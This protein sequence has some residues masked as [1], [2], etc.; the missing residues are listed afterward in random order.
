MTDVKMPQMGESIAEGTISVWLIDEGQTVKAD[1]PLVTVSTDK[2]DV[3]VP[4][5][6][7]GV[8]AE[9]IAKEGETVQVGALIA[10]IDE[11]TIAVG[12]EAQKETPAEAVAGKPETPAA[13]PGEAA[14]GQP[15][16]MKPS[17]GVP[18][19]EIEKKVETAKVETAPPQE[20]SEAKT[21]V[22]GKPPEM[23]VKRD[24]PAEHP[25][26]PEG[27]PAAEAKRETRPGE[28]VTAPPEIK[29]EV[30][31]PEAVAEA[32]TDK[33]GFYSP[34]VMRLA[35]EHGV[36]LKAIEGTGEG[37]RVTRADVMRVLGEKRAGPEGTVPPGG[38]VHAPEKEMPSPRI[39]Q[40]ELLES[41]AP[42]EMQAGYGVYKPPS[43]EVEEGD[44][45]LPFSR[46]RLLIA[47][48]MVYSK[49]TSA[50]V[51]T[52]AEADFEQIV[53]IRQ[54]SKDKVKAEVGISL[55][56]TPFVMAAAIRILKEFPLM[57][58]VVQGY[59]VL[60]KRH[61]NLGVAVDSE[62]GLMVPVIKAAED[63]SLLDLAKA[64]H[65]LSV[66]VRDKK[67]T[68]DE[69]TGGTFTVTNPGRHGNLFG[70]PIISQPQVGI[71]R[72][73]E[74]VKRAVV[75]TAED[76]EDAIAIRPMMYLALS[77]DHRVVDGLT[78]NE[79]LHRIKD[80]LEAGDF[81]L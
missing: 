81:A 23:A 19:A 36:D 73:G 79:F 8:L 38:P 17:E 54:R 28:E 9:I 70:T 50:H 45:E 42:P 18:G 76:G 55:T 64:L 78:A 14:S 27:V 77:Y 60:T 43:Y 74:L 31:E 39:V 21:T 24:G 67:I 71:L 5:P 48:H 58:S 41:A 59:S 47:D 16:A 61:I 3:D 13:K 69:L 68:P 51:T 25:A 15:E 7:S 30:P 37:G 4:S 72:M 26:R 6:I 53:G 65:A 12:T 40:E 57:N 75:V 33:S 22:E 29:R 56:Y 34:A 52:I 1:E 2:A 44:A 11:K 32:M 20:T 63:M 66:R 62:R 46:L 80:H 35:M 49:R 10:R